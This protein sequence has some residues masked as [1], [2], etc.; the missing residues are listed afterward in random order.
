MT[1][2]KIVITGGP[3]A[4]KTEAHAHVKQHFKAKRYTVLTVAETATELI[5][6]GVAPWSCGSH[7]TYQN[8][9]LQLQLEKERIFTK[10]AATMSAKDVLIFFD[11]GALDGKAY[12]TDADY[13]AMVAAL[14][15]NEDALLARYDAVFHLTTAAKGNGYTLENNAARTETAAE[16]VAIDDR[17]LQVWEKHP[18]RWIIPCTAEPAQKMEQLTTAITAFLKKENNYEALS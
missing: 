14:G 10:A 12:M 7:P 13:N 1:V 2:T 18:H 4:G 15:T 16:A 9:L 11:R 3:C 17:T 6:G 5:S 8:F